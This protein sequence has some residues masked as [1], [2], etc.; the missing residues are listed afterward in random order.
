MVD[1][2]SGVESRAGVKDIGLIEAFMREV[3]SGPCGQAA[4]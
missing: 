4:G 2:S 3:K 1:V